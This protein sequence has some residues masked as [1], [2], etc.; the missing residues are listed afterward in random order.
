[1]YLFFLSYDTNETHPNSLK[2]RGWKGKM[3]MS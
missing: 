3:K 2:G 1:M